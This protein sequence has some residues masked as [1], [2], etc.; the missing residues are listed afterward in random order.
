MCVAWQSVF[1]F[2]A[3]YFNLEGQYTDF[4]GITI[5]VE[6]GTAN[7]V[8]PVALDFIHSKSFLF[9][10]TLDRFDFQPSWVNAHYAVGGT[11]QDLGTNFQWRGRRISES[12]KIGSQYR[13]ISHEFLLV[14]QQPAAHSMF[15]EVGGI[16]PFSRESPSMQN[17][18]LRLRSRE[19]RGRVRITSLGR[20]L[21][22]W[23]FSSLS[24]P[25]LVP[26][27]WSF[28]ATAYF[29]S[30]PLG[31]EIVEVD[32]STADTLVPWRMWRSMINASAYV[33]MDPTSGR[34]YVEEGVSNDALPTFSFRIG[35]RRTTVRLL[36]KSLRFPEPYASANR[37][38]SLISG[39]GIV[40]LRVR[41][42][43]DVARI[44]IGKALL[45]SYKDVF[46]DNIEG[47][48]RLIPPPHGRITLFGSPDPLVPWILR[49]P[50]ALIVDDIFTDSS[51]SLRALF[52][53]N[54]DSPLLLPPL[55]ATC[56]DRGL[57]PWSYRE[58]L[59]GS[60]R[61]S[62]Q[63]R[64]VRVNDRQALMPPR[65]SS[66]RLDHANLGFSA[67]LENGVS[68]SKTSIPADHRLYLLVQVRIGA[69]EVSVRIEERGLLLD[70]PRP[71]AA[72]DGRSDCSVCF[73]E[74]GAG[75]LEQILPLC[76]HKFHARCIYPWFHNDKR[77]CPNCRAQIPLE[78]PQP[79]PIG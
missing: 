53:M 51:I 25:C 38:V 3:C 26:A 71:A 35:Q 78:T 40:P 19:P 39:R 27:N 55:P 74:I 44:L 42:V 57:I 63:L 24:I 58:W 13:D 76:K 6:I 69:R 64:F 15:Q 62:F 75:E 52:N 30:V 68:L 49:R 21:L 67:S 5:P 37:K 59:D 41:I 33:N 31:A 22:P 73:D 18:I 29:G 50:T 14:E 28:Q 1:T 45:E 46:L 16:I 10:N 61:K 56:L 2:A 12:L 36:S 79:P 17:R 9:S 66:F 54:S 48:I 4:S 70:I 60:S 20:R 8:I 32:P 65:V 7:Q 72:A 77:T 23:P 34:L 47:K 43:S 11:T